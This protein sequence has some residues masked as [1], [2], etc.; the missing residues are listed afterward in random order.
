MMK[1]EIDQ[2]IIAIGL[3]PCILDSE[4][5]LNLDWWHIIKILLATGLPVLGPLFSS[6]QTSESHELR[7]LTLS[8]LCVF[9]LILGV[10]TTQT[11]VRQPKTELN[12]IEF[13][14]ETE[15]LAVVYIGDVK[16]LQEVRSEVYVLLLLKELHWILDPVSAIFQGIN[17]V[18]VLVF[19]T[20]YFY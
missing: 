11:V 20:V 10:E 1:K 9:Q 2:H 3:L 18:R 5:T 17:Y 15:V 6:N 13:D 8:R 19:I 4:T 7:V 12:C 16:H 14:L